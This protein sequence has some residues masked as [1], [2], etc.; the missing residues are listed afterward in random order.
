MFNYSY[1]FSL[2]HYPPTPNRNFSILL[3]KC[4]KYSKFLQIIFSK[5]PELEGEISIA[6]CPERVL[7]GNI[8][9]ELVQ[10]DRV[11]GGIDEKSTKSAKNFYKKLRI[12]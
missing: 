7:P 9:K 5:R 2:P 1:A 3:F 10:N 11:V 6:Y 12:V 4:F 8:I